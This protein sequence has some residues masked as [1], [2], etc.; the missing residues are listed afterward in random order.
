M[1]QVSVWH[2]GRVPLPPTFPDLRSLD[3]FTSVVELGSLSRAA[4]AHGIAQPSASS[5]IKHLEQ[6]LGIALLD[7]SP[8]GSTPTD[9]GVVVAGWADAILRAA[10]EL[11]A[12]LSAVR[13]A[14]SGR[15]R[16]AASFTIAE[17]LLPGWL[18]RFSREHPR[19][20]VAL[21]VANSSTVIER[22]HHGDADLGFIESPLDTPSLASQV[23]AVDRL[24]TVVAP[25]HPWVRRGEVPVE[26][27][28]ATPLVTREAGSGTRAAL[29]LALADLHLGEPTAVLELGSTA[30]VRAA[31]LRGNAPTVISHLAVADDLASGALV[32]IRVN[33]LDITRRLRA[34]W[35]PG[36][37]PN[38]LARALLDD[39][40]GDR[41]ERSYAADIQRH[42]AGYR[43]QPP[44]GDDEW[45]DLER[46]TLPAGE[47]TSHRLDE[48]ERRL[49]RKS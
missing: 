26:A 31:V 12:G 37:A 36:A 33:G 40:A 5:R 22:L 35:R 45:G 14:K 48:K 44:G 42:V 21:H 25:N 17:Y 20:S 28:A 19:D 16:I 47:A 10:H 46:Q 3:L 4:R 13:A 34:V 41:T 24:V 9:A 6:Q 43:A 29:E 2:D 30:A 15:L 1:A 7:R 27:L 23:V 39:L 32:E 8:A 18:D 11:D 38:A 49:G